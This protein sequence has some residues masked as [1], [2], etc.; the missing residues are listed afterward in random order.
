M[1]GSHPS[2]AV[3]A[4]GESRVGELAQEAR[5]RSPD[6]AHRFHF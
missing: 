2:V 4:D 1:R 3:V 6:R 5:P